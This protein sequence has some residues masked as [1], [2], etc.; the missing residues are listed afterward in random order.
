MENKDKLGFLSL[1]NMAVGMVIGAGI[2]TMLTEMVG[3]TGRSLC[4]AVALGAVLAIINSIPVVFLSSTIE[5]EGGNYSQGMALL[6]PILAG[7]NGII[8][9]ISL[10]GFGAYTLGMAS[11]TLQ[12]IP[13]ASGLY[14]AVAT[15]YLI[16]FFLFGL[17]GTKGAANI[18]NIMMV[19]LF[20]SLGVFIFRGLPAI[21]PGYFRQEGFY[22]GGASGFMYASAM[23]SMSSMGASS[24]ISFT[25]ESKNPKRDIPLAMFVGTLAV[26]IIYFLM[27][28]VTAGVL[29]IE[30]VQ[31]QN[32]GVVA[33][34]FLSRPMYIFFVIGGALFAMGTSLNGLLAALPAPFIKMAEDGWLPKFFLNRDKK[35]N[36]PYVIMG[37]YFIIGG[38]LPLVLNMNIATISA[39]FS[40]P[41]YL[42]NVMVALA[43]LRIPTLYP[44]LWKKATFHCPKPLFVFLVL[45]GAASSVYL[46]YNFVANINTSLVIGMFVAMGILSGYIVYRY[47]AGFVNI[48]YMM[49]NLKDAPAE[50]E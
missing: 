11:Y 48:D 42:I 10:F 30:Q 43:T 39:F 41:N 19:C 7:I 3:V 36:Y 38:I 44:N 13:N 12:L 26:A 29:P 16:L 5:L 20:L 15:I 45:L 33:E 28:M 2:F 49:E 17:K 21:E 4:Y 32:L 25:R 31:G 22:L 9:Q 6:P 24:I 34:A 14:K 27:A 35:F 46:A 8:K 23:L 37:M 40:F 47:K 1:F 18:Q 50:E